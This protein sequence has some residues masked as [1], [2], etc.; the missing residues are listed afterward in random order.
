MAEPNPILWRPG[1]Q[2]KTQSQM[3]CYLAWLEQNGHGPFAD[4][5]ALHTWSTTALATFWRTVW[6]YAGLIAEKPP[7]AMLSKRRMPGAQWLPGT[8][9]NFARNLLRHALDG[10]TDREAVV[11]MAECRLTVRKSYGELLADVGAFEVFLREHD[12]QVGDRVA[13]WISNGYEALVAM[14]ATTSL[15]AVWTSTSPEFGVEAT[16]DRFG[17]VGPKVLIAV[18]GYAYAGRSY[19]RSEQV[20]ALLERLPSV[21]HTVLIEQ[22]PG[23]P[24]PRGD[25]ITPWPMALARGKGARPAFTLLPASHPVY[26]LYSSGTAG[27]PRC[28][29]HGA[30]GVLLN[31]AKELLLHM[32]VRG[33]GDRFFYFTTCGWMMW[34]WQASVLMT[35]A[36]LVCYDGA[37]AH[38][39]SSMLWRIAAK[40]RLTHFGTRTQFLAETRRQALSPAQGLELDHLRIVFSTGSRL[41][42]E[43]YDWFYRSVSSKIMLSSLAG[44]AE[45][46]GSFL[47]SN[48]LLPVRR[49]ELQCALLGADVAAYAPNGT[50]LEHGRGEL[51]CRRPLPSMP[52]AFWNDKD[53]AAYRAAYFDTFPGVWAQGDY[54][55]ITPS[56]GAIVYGRSDA[57][58]NPHGVRIGSAEIYRQVDTVEAV[59]DSLVVARPIEGDVEIVL[60]VVL[61]QGV[62]LDEPL[63]A[64]I[65]QR[66]RQNA[67]P[68]HVPKH[69]VPVEDIPYALSG[70]KVELAVARMLQGVEHHSLRE[71]LANPQAL[72]G[73][74]ERLRELMPN[75]QTLSDEC[76]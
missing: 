24:V 21:R 52:V 25:R 75:G 37:P 14:L 38:P 13:A 17:Q 35:G 58:L 65:E 67:S 30:G 6:D 57:T 34:N 60:L 29:V 43:D 11:A 71:T 73:I 26:I 41:L 48:P 10:G 28:I 31:H 12:V 53:G 1:R 22:L 4:Y 47:G 42:G 63:R 56:G 74:R 18:N 23:A 70:K 33:P 44:G 36:T 9:L 51:V 16:L 49:G 3:A 66:I 8:R 62:E 20:H 55:E 39:D 40:E 7:R 2:Q 46:C 54:V 32:D 72:D 69:I 76:A 50:R 61:R 68:R 5:Q 59:R 64:L 45:I 27:K 19:S 15:G